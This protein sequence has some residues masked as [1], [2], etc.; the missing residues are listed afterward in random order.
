MIASETETRV[1]T[2][3]GKKRPLEEFRLRSRQTGQRRPLGRVYEA[4]PGYDLS[5]PLPTAPGGSSST[6]ASGSSSSTGADSYNAALTLDGDTIL[7]QARTDYDAAG[8]VLLS[9]LWRRLHNATG[10]GGA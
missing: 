2:S 6:S 7:E 8:N 10:T 1:C 4:F 9:A 5:E 3:C